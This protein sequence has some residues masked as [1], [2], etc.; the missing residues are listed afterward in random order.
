MIVLNY[1]RVEGDDRV[2]RRSEFVTD[3]RE[4]F[5]GESRLSLRLQCGR[6]ERLAGALASVF[7]LLY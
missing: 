3:V 2:E 4:E 6:V 1:E 5:V 7:V